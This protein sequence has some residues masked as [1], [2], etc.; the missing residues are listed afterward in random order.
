[1]SV[2]AF[3]WRGRY[4][5]P[6]S[7]SLL[8]VIACNYL[9][10]TAILGLA[11]LFS[12]ILHFIP[13]LPQ[14]TGYFACLHFSA[15]VLA[16]GAA[17]F[18]GCLWF[19]LVITGRVKGVTWGG[20]LV[21]GV[22]LA[23]LDVPVAGLIAGA[24]YGSPLLGFLLGLVILLIHPGVLFFTSCAGALLGCVNGIV[25]TAWISQWKRRK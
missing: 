24:L 11:L 2:T 16:P 6:G 19:W 21:Y 22:C 13:V 4:G 14:E 25:A 10:S 1:M 9:L 5:R 15:I 12:D 8:A 17:I 18:Y 3:G 7:A 20:A 23:L